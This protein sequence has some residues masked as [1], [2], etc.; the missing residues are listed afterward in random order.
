MSNTIRCPNTSSFGG[1]VAAEF[2]GGPPKKTR[3][4]KKK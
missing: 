1:W 3:A 4:E 2:I